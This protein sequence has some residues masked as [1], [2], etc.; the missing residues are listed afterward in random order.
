MEESTIKEYIADKSSSIISDIV[1]GENTTTITGEEIK[2]LLTENKELIEE[3]F[4]IVITEEEIE[5]VA[6][7]VEELPVVQEIQKNGVAGF[8]G[9]GMTVPD[10]SYDESTDSTTPS[11]PM[12]GINEILN[13]VRMIASDTVFYACIGACAIL[14]ALLFL[15]AWNKP[16]IALFYS[17]STFFTTGLTFL[18]PTLIATT[19]PATWIGLFS[20]I[21]EIGAMIGAVSRVVLMLTGSVCYTVTG[22]GL[23]LF[24][25]GIV[26][27]SVM[28]KIKKAKAA[29]AAAAP[30]TE[31]AP[32]AEET[33]PAEE[34]APVEEVVAEE[35]APAE[36]VV[37]EEDAPAEEVAAEE[38]APAEETEPAEVPNA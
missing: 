19:Q 2:E 26:V 1:T 27:F 9:G 32:V 14:I 11:N 4:D 3:H 21:P 12:G 13:T 20:N 29:K 7:A 31:T 34:V 18:V 17:G 25:L 30:I 22:I 8:L 6:Q 23:A 33:A 16:Y 10:G 35:D 28:K 15:L 36:E 24:V 38:D 5:E 37:A